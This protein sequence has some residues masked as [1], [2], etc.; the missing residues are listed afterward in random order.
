MI[1]KIFTLVT[2]LILVLLGC[3]SKE[4]TE[5]DSDIL[6]YNVTTNKE[7]YTYNSDTVK[8]ENIKQHDIKD[9]LLKQSM[10]ELY[11]KTH[12][13]SLYTN[14][15]SPVDG[16]YLAFELDS[17]GIIYVK[18]TTWNSYSRLKCINDSI[19]NIINV[20]LENIILNHEFHNIDISKF[21]EKNIAFINPE[22]K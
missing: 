14:L 11:G 10:F 20:A 19:D 9:T 16:G 21:H 13:I 6:F 18:S 5:K 3:Y 4:N 8:I 15:H 2:F 22:L 12:W 1:M 17:I 7:F